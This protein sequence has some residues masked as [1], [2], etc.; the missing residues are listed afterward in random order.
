MIY[1][2]LEGDQPHEMRNFNSRARA[3]DFNNG[4]GANYYGLSTA[5]AQPTYRNLRGFSEGHA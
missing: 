3:A 1:R 2:Q 4:A 5:G